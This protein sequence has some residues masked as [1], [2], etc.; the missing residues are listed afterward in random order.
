M[1]AGLLN[2]EIVILRPETTR[3]EFGE[4]VTEYKPNY[5]TKARILHISGQR[6]I[7]D[8]E[9]L[10]SYIKTIE[11]WQYVGITETDWIEY[12]GKKYRILEIEPDKSQMKKIIR[13][14]LINE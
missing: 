2:E 8:G 3:N 9:I 4:Q 6:D 13:L 10:H 12:D 11:I 5:K 1:Q 14:E 7:L